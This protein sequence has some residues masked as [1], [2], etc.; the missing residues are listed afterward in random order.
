LISEVSRLLANKDKTALFYA[1]EARIRHDY[2]LTEA[3]KEIYFEA[4]ALAR[5]REARADRARKGWQRRRARQKDKSRRD[6]S[7]TASVS[8]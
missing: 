5:E 8:L 1:I 2:Y 6:A 3:L 4:L 7:P